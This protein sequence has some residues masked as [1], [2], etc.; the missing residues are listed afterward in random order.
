MYINNY[1]YI[2]KKKT[3]YNNNY[4]NKNIKNIYIFICVSIYLHYI[5][6]KDFCI[7]NNYI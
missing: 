2:F 6:T 5:N 7:Q 4:M 3:L 1:I